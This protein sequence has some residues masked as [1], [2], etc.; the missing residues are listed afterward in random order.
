ML[1]PGHLVFIRC[2]DGD[3]CFYKLHLPPCGFLSQVA[4]AEGAF[5]AGL[6]QPAPPA[7]APIPQALIL[8]DTRMAFLRRASTGTEQAP[9]CRLIPC[10]VPLS[11]PRPWEAGWGVTHPGSSMPGTGFGLEPKCGKC[12]LNE[13][14][15]FSS[16]LRVLFALSTRQIYPERRLPR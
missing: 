4:T 14:I 2:G 16:D 1:L 12:L 7:W 15:H 5:G 9:D 8:A 10:W 13:L 6:P 11:P 3:H